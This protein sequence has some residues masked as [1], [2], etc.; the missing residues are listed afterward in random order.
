MSE[1]EI[2]EELKSLSP[3]EYAI[4]N[5]IDLFNSKKRVIENLQMLLDKEKEKNKELEQAFNED[6]NKLVVHFMENHISKD[7]IRNKINELEKDEDSMENFLQIGILED[8]LK[9]N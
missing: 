8:L 4:M 6:Y 9:E 2:L 3:S 7:K 5:M 1:D